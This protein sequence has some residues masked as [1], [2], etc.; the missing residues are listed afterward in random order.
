MG[1][2]KRRAIMKRTER[3]SLD[4]FGGRVHVAW[5]SQGAVSPLEELLFFIEFL[6]VSGL[7]E[8]YIKS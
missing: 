6:K 4:T 8:H 5:D 3:I 1:D 2:N 7:F